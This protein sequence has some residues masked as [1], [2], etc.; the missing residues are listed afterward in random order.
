MSALTTHLWRAPARALALTA[1]LAIALIGC[2]GGGGDS[3][4]PDPDPTPQQPGPLPTPDPQ[5]PRPSVEGTYVLEQI[6][7]SEPGQLVTIANPDGVVVGLYRF[8]AT[9][10]TLTTVT[11]FELALRY[12]DDKTQDGIDDHGKLTQT[13]P[14]SQ[15]AVPYTFASAVYGDS[16]TG[17]V[18]QDIVAIKYDFDGDGQPETT[19]GFRRVG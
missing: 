12:T 3:T 4:G 2:G 19:F 1:A 16:F 15:G 5:A 10:L 9:T 7:G 6:N 11:T 14:A 13:G 8:E 18:L 17:V